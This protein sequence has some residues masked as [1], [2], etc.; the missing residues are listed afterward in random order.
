MSR[1]TTHR[2]E[3]RR[4][5]RARPG[6]S[7]FGRPSSGRWILGGLALGL[8]ASPWTA[9]AATGVTTSSAPTVAAP[10]A[11]VATHGGLMMHVMAGLHGLTGVH[12]GHA[13]FFA[14]AGPS[15]PCASSMGH[16][17]GMAVIALII[18]AVLRFRH[19]AARGR[20]DLAR[21]MVEKGME[22]PAELVGGGGF[23]D[24]RRGLVLSSAGLGFLL[25]GTINSPSHPSGAGLIP[26][27]VGIGYLLSH[28]FA[29][30]RTSA[31]PGVGSASPRSRGSVSHE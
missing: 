9:H 31:P 6:W 12:A 22:P 19:A 23:A 3:L 14:D 21:R 15:S 13:S 17:A 29:R 1:P 10:M 30:P 16:L 20:I 27:F 18:I 5:L 24:L 4:L 2:H 26:L 11:Q 28:R 8:L 7:E 25:Y